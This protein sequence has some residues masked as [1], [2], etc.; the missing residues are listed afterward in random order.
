[1]V[2]ENIHRDVVH[3]LRDRS[4]SVFDVAEEGRSVF[5]MIDLIRRP[6]EVQ[7]AVAEQSGSIDEATTS[8]PGLTNRHKLLRNGGGASPEVATTGR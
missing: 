3:F 8:R 7:A 5:P 1:M 2:D 4:F 6:H